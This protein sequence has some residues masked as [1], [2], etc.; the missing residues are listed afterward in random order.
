M[1]L[2]VV[3][4]GAD[5]AVTAQ[6]AGASRVELV[7]QF[8]CGGLTP[9]ARTV[10][11]VASA[12]TIPVHVMLR[13]HDRGYCYDAADRET[14]LSAALRLKESGARA[15]VFGAL[16]D[17][18]RIDIDLLRDVLRIARLPITFHRAFDET[19]NPSAGYA[20]LAGIHGVERV[21]TSGHAKNAWDGRVWLR[22]LSLGN[23]LPIVLAAGGIDEENLPELLRF[24]GVREVHVGRGVR[25]NGAL[26]GAKV[27]RLARI[28]T[29]V[30]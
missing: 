18:N 13:P 6:N 16:D 20:T 26:D 10:E 2:E 24:T 8:A 11:A 22:D 15:I 14:I 27:E 4:T 25:S 12:L 30:A 9:D 7:T 23:T 21:L 5:E 19:L 28:L 3:V 1:Q 17:R 29:G